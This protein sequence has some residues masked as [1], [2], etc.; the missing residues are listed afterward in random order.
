[1]MSET[2]VTDSL[3]LSVVVP[4]YNERENLVPLEEE[5]QEHLGNLNIDYEILFIDDGSQDGSAQLIKELQFR[6]PRIRWIR[7]K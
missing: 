3:D 1:M 7:F 2:I 6:N 4:V 5:L